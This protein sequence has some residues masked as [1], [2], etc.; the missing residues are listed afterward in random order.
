LKL[1]R[2]LVVLVALVALAAPC[3][4]AWGQPA[5]QL[6]F[7]AA[8]AVVRPPDGTRTPL[9]GVERKIAVRD[10]AVC[11]AKRSPEIRDWVGVVR[12][13]EDDGDV[14]HLTIAIGDHVAVSNLIRPKGR[15]HLAKRPDR[16]VNATPAV[17]AALAGL[18]RGDRVLFSGRLEP[19]N[20][21]GG[22]CY[23]LENLFIQERHDKPEYSMFFI[24]IEKF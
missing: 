13:N 24:K 18:R 20:L 12:W 10:K 16:G 14:V 21:F 3:G 4:A 15:P 19:P 8:N 1:V 22:Q 2:Q 5:D 9:K 7:V 17:V 11:A 23:G 6:A